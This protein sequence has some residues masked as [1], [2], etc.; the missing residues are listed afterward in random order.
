MDI[1]LMAAAVHGVHFPVYLRL[2][3]RLEK[4]FKR[5]NRCSEGK[6]GQSES[7]AVS[8]K[9]F[10][11]VSILVELPDAICECLSVFRCHHHAAI[12]LSHNICNVRA[13]WNIDDKGRAGHHNL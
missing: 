3:N 8:P 13:I 4:A 10:Q 5:I 7:S 9:S 12:G 11:V 1:C 6:A 2:N